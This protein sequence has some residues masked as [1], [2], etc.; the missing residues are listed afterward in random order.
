MAT[1][2]NISGALRRTEIG[3]ELFWYGGGDEAWSSLAVALAGIPSAVRKGKTFGVY[4]AGY[5][6]EYWWPTAA[7]A[8]GDVVLK[9]IEAITG[10][11]TTNEIAYFTAAQVIAS[12]TTATYPNLTELSYVKGVTSAIQTQLNGKQDAGAAAGGELA[13][14]YPNPTLLNAAVIAKVLT[15]LSISGGSITAADTILSAFGKVQNQIN[16]LLGGVNYQGVWNATTNSPTLTSSVGTKGYYYVVSVAGSTNLNG[17]T[18]WKLDD[19]AI[20][21]GTSWEKVDN[22]DAVISVNGQIGTVVLTTADISEVTNLYFTQARVLAT[23]LTGFSAAAGTVTATDTILQAFN[24]IVANVNNL[25]AA[26]ADYIIFDTI[27]SGALNT[28]I[29][30]NA[31]PFP[32]LIYINDKDCYVYGIAADEIST[33]AFRAGSWDGTDYVKGYAGSYDAG[34]TTFIEQGRFAGVPGATETFAKGYYLGQELISLTGNIKYIC[35][36]D[37]TWEAQSGTYTPTFTPDG[38]VCTSGSAIT[39]SATFSK[40]GNICTVM[41]RVKGI[42]LDFSAGTVGTLTVDT[43]PITPTAVNTAYGTA[44]ISILNGSIFTN[45]SE[46]RISFEGDI[47]SFWCLDTAFIVSGIEAIITMQYRIS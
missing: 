31:V 38:V 42:D 36:G 4:D 15:G 17:I 6:K 1:N 21:N 29:G 28:L 5:L 30:T 47:I 35:T 39:N 18:D 14:N 13:G 33:F 9:S 27:A 11:G 3:S 37:G 41:L 44:N 46:F 43:F 34:S 23:L 16:A 24:K 8:D 40:V 20:F 12:L 7:I 26:L 10:S 45:A 22:T 2:L 19:W 32:S 25:E